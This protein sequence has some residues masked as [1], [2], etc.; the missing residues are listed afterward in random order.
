MTKEEIK[1][2]DALQRVLARI[3]TVGYSETEYY[4][5]MKVASLLKKIQEDKRLCHLKPAVG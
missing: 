1:A 5:I 4:D 3:D 2:R